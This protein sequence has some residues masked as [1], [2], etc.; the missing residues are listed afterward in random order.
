MPPPSHPHTHTRYGALTARDSAPSDFFSGPSGLASEAGHPGAAIPAPS[1]AALVALS[2][3]LGRAPS[4]SSSSSSE[5]APKRLGLA[6]AKE[7]LEVLLDEARVG[8]PAFQG[9]GRVFGFDKQ[10]SSAVSAAAAAPV[11]R[12][13]AE[14]AEA[15]G[16]WQVGDDKGELRS[17]ARAVVANPRLAADL[18]EWQAA[19]LAAAGE[20]GVNNKAASQKKAAKVGKF[21]LGQAMRATKG[22]AEPK[23]LTAAVEK[24]LQESLNA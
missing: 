7:V 16:L 18:A 2:E 3:G 6:A 20:G 1:F 8:P 15:L 13:P 12:S 19:A 4:S 23:A 24:A 22:R 11:T 21:F 5:A 10:A 17:V 14:V 9:G